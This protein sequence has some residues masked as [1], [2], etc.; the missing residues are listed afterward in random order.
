MSRYADS[1]RASELQNSTDSWVWIFGFD[2]LSE[3]SE[4]WVGVPPARD[5]EVYGGGEALFCNIPRVE[6]Y[7]SIAFIRG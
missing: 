6:K 5:R 4:F 1:G 3:S 7:L 2:L